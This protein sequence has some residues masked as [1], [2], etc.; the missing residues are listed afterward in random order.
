MKL[1][2]LSDLHLGKRVNNFP[3]LEDRAYILDRI[4]EIIEGEQYVFGSGNFSTAPTD[5][6]HHLRHYLQRSAGGLRHRPRRRDWIL[7]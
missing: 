1:I 6:Y 2:H 3:M 5:D 4:L 7:V